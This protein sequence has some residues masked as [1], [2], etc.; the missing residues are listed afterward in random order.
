LEVLIFVLR[1][2]SKFTGQRDSDV[3]GCPLQF[4][5]QNAD[6]ALTAASVKFHINIQGL[7]YNIHT[8]QV[9]ALRAK[10]REQHWSEP[11]LTVSVLSAPQYSLCR[12][13]VSTESSSAARRLE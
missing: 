2:M 12:N 5:A 1:P 7:L 9:N 4:H 11:S 3:T 10:C 13:L 8:V 6:V